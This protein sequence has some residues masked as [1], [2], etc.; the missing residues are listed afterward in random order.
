[1]ENEQQQT[2]VPKAG[3][4]EL[5]LVAQYVQDKVQKEDPATRLILNNTFQAAFDTLS[6]IVEGASE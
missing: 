6:K 1:M 3:V 5:G 2:T 4:N